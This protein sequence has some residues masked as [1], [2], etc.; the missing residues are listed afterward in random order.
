MPADRPLTAS[1]IRTIGVISD[2]HGLLRPEALEA[3]AGSELILHGGDIGKAVVL[4]ELARIAPV[5]AIR[6]NV[7]RDAWADAIPMSRTLEIAGNRIHLLHNIADLVENPDQPFHAIIFG[8]SH[9]PLSEHRKGALYF[10]PGSAGPRRFR[11]PVTVGRLRVS[12]GALIPEIIN[13]GI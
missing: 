8:H 12:D 6:G 3:L 5:I 1:E 9:R 10:N 7:D 4:D 2:T 11:L 13:L